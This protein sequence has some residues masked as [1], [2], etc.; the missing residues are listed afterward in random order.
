MNPALQEALSKLTVRAIELIVV[1]LLI[2]GFLE[3]KQHARDAAD[4]KKTAEEAKA[5]A[6]AAVK[7]GATPV[8]I[9]SA[10]EVAAQVK[11]DLVPFFA[12]MVAAG[13]RPKEV[14]TAQSTFSD[15]SRGEETR[16]AGNPCPAHV[17]DVP[18]RRFDFDMTKEPPELTRLQKFRAQLGIAETPNGKQKFTKF[19]LQELD[20]HTGAELATTGITTDLKVEV[21]PDL[22]GAPGPW[23]VRAAVLAGTMG[24][25]VGAQ[26]NPWS[27]LLLTVGGTYK[28]SDPRGVFGLGWRLRFPGFDSTLGLNLLATYGKSGFHGDAGGSAEITR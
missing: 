25:G 3:Y 19:Q 27:G 5:I 2:F 28:K 9:V 13:A 8:Q 1:G 22:S 24:F 21:T 12:A 26:L 18:A 10:K 23:H 15:K 14:A 16:V 7:Q 4:A 17:V 20:P 6:A 11:G